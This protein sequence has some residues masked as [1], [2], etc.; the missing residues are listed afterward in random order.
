MYSMQILA[1]RGDRLVLV[2]QS[3]G[4]RN[5]PSSEV[6]NVSQF[7][8]NVDKLEREVRFDSDDLDAA[9]TALDEMNAFLGGLS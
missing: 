5:G 8:E 4:Y 7:D 9:L 3:M 6:L 1:V 2:R